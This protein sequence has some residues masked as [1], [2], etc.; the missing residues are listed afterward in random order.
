MTLR[1]SGAAAAI[2]LGLALS[3]LAGAVPAAAQTSPGLPTEVALV[4][5]LTV[6]AATTGLIPADLLE[7]Y[8]SEFGL[9]TRSLDQVADRPV[10]LA[11][12]PM[13]IASIRVLGADAPDSAVAW[14]DRLAALSNES[15]ALAWA[16]SDL[17]LGVNAGGGTVLTPES[18]DFAIVADRFG[19][20]EPEPTAD[21]SATASASPTAEP[22]DDDAPPPLPTTESLL[23][24]QY[25][26]DS[27]GWPQADT[28]STTT[29]PALAASFEY[30]LL[31]SSNLG[32]LPSLTATATVGDAPV[33][34]S[35]AELSS[36]FTATVESSSGTQWETAVAALV[37][38]TAS[39]ST[40]STA[41]SAVVV[42]D[43]STSLTDLDLGATIDA[44][45][46]IPTVELVGLSAVADNAGPTATIVDKAQDAASIESV[47]SLLKTEGLDATFA[48]IADDPSRVT[49]ERRLDL[50]AT[51]S[52][53]WDSDAAGWADA[54]STYRAASTDLRAMVK[55]IKS[56][57][58]TLWADRGS[59][60]VI[61]ENTLDQPVT[62]YVTVRPLSPLVRVDD[63]FF[64]VVVEPNSQRKASV[65]VQSISN[66]VVELEISLHG[67]QNQQIGKTTYVRTTVQ[68][69]WETPFTIGVG[70]LVILVFAAGVVRTI[71]RLRRARAER[72][73]IA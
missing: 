56:S 14:L 55:I 43:R 67:I 9:L 31:S 57:S 7:N 30:S 50:L 23:E 65:P 13:I 59:L 26:L 47:K 41:D 25:S 73:T 54:V 29:M 24:W 4:V 6:P 15:F 68:A 32:G 42:L 62:V 21:P 49:S 10:T 60:P 11:I 48:R 18:L 1:P 71:V 44:L 5:P 3:P 58:I 38:S 22:D 20:A 53:S 28:V 34:V 17:T 70:I 36:L 16:D 12:D 61:V 46:A 33:I 66:G 69:G 19:A 37:A 35:D 27:V 2:V 39:A 64:E 45:A 63:T 52:N 72:I 40:E 8:T 51:L